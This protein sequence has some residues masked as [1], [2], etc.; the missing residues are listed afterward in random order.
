LKSS[1]E[2]SPNHLAII[3]VEGVTG[4]T[5]KKGVLAEIFYSF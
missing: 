5:G 2:G 1:E 4:D 3:F